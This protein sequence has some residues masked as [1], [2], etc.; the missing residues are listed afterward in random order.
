[1]VENVCREGRKLKQQK[2]VQYQLGTVNG[3]LTSFVSEPYNVKDVHT[4]EVSKQALQNLQ[5]NKN[6]VKFSPKEKTK[7]H[8][9]REGVMLVRQEN[10]WETLCDVVAYRVCA[11][12]RLLIF[13]QNYLCIP[14]IVIEIADRKHSEYVIPKEKERT[15]STSTLGKAK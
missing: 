8:R 11:S 9:E 2:K 15:L 3:S 6:N 14:R 4:A 12:V 10:S 13:A 1:M 5:K 7:T